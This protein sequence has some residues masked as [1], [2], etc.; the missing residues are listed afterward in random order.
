MR[1][2]YEYETNNTGK[3]KFD[4]VDSDATLN[5][6]ADREMTIDGPK[7]LPTDTYTKEGYKIIGWTRKMG[8]RNVYPDFAEGNFIYEGAEIDD[9]S[10]GSVVIDYGVRDYFSD[11]PQLLESYEK[12]ISNKYLMKKESVSRYTKE[13]IMEK[14]MLPMKIICLKSIKLAQK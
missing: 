3:I 13:S 12:F 6:G 14:N 9:E 4:C 2:Q 1:V 10:G 11:K 7:T 5:V 8:M